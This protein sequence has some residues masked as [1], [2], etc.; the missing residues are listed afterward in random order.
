MATKSRPVGDMKVSVILT[1]LNEGNGLAELLDALLMQTARPDEIVVVDGGSRDD[2]LKVLN[3]YAQRDR[4]FK[5]YVEPGVNIARGRNLAIARAEGDVLAITDAGCRPEPGWLRELLLPLQNDPAVG[6]V[7]GRFIPVAQGRFEYYCGQLS[8]PDLGGESQRGMFYG[9]SSAFRRRLWERVG[10]YPEWLYTGEDT[11]FAIS[12]GRIGDYKIVYAPASVLS[13]RPRPT[14]PKMAKMFYLYGRGNGRIQHGDLQGSLYWLRYYFV[15][16]LTLPLGLFSV[17]P[18]VISTIVFWHLYRT[19][20]KPNLLLIKTR[21]DDSIDRY[22]YIPLIA[23][24]RN[25]STNLGF[26]RGWLEY[27][28]DDVFKRKLEEYLNGTWRRETAAGHQSGDA[29]QHS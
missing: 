23:L 17:W 12:A 25:L 15:L 6:A 22:F 20:V 10:G 13:W 4:R 7:G 19:V 27:R 21:T 5:I 14:L 16:A 9:R 26:V 1:V 18:W 3:A 29:G 28:N 24:T 11:L 2:T 8:V